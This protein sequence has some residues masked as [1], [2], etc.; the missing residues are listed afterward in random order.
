MKHLAVWE[1]YNNT[2]PHV[3]KDAAK[4]YTPDEMLLIQDKANQVI[5]CFARGEWQRYEWR[6][7]T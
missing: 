2:T 5:A 6:S 4:V 1:T 7:E 3:Y